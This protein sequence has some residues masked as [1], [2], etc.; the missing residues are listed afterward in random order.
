ME[1]KKKNT[2]SAASKTKAPQPPA[3]PVAEVEQT[4][5]GTEVEEPKVA[6]DENVGHLEP[7][8]PAAPAAGDPDGSA[9]SP[10]FRGQ[11]A[12]KIAEKHVPNAKVDTKTVEPKAKS[13][14][15][16][17]QLAE[18]YAKRYPDNKIFHITTDKQVFL[19][20]DLSLAIMHQATLKAV[21]KVRSITVK[22][23]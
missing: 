19:Q 10:E 13:L 21:E 23:E 9:P 16:Y 8:A 20:G 5:A 17:E 22:S 3:T 6:D 11:T 12:K 4:T 2:K 18:Q 1:T 14:D 7:I 15:P